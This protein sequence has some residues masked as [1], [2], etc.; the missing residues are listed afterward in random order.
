MLT[1]TG[2]KKIQVTVLVLFGAAGVLIGFM[3]D[4]HFKITNSA[5]ILG[6]AGVL[7][8]FLLSVIYDTVKHLNYSHSSAPYKNLLGFFAVL[9]TILMMSFFSHDVL[10]I[11]TRIVA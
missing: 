9:L 11:L 1:M 7:I 6:P 4:D 2:V 10:Q 3:I 5:Y 8:G